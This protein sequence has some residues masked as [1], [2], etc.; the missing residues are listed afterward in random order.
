MKTVKILL[1][2]L[3]VCTMVLSVVSCGIFGGGTGN[4]GNEIT[5]N[6]GNE[7]SGSQGGGGDYVS[8]GTYGLKYQLNADGKSYTVTGM[9]EYANANN[10][11]I[12]EKYNG[13]P[14]TAIGEKAFFERSH[15]MS[16]DLP[17]TV[18]SIGK[19]AF[20]SCVRL[21]TME[22]PKSMTDGSVARGCSTLSSDDSCIG[23]DA[24]AG[25]E[26][27]VEVVNN[28]ELNIVAGSED[29][30]EVAL[31][32]IEVHDGESKITHVGD[33]RFY[34]FAGKNYL[35]SYYGD[36][37]N[38][39]LPES[40]NG[41]GYHINDYA[42]SGREQITKVV[43][44]DSVTG[45]GEH[46]FYFCE[47]LKSV[48]IGDGV[49]G[50][51]EETFA[52]CEKLESIVIGES[53]SSIGY[54][55]FTNCV[56][57]QS[58][59]ISNIAAWCNMDLHQPI[60]WNGGNLYLKDGEE[61]TL[62]TNLVIP[63]G[64][65]KIG[66]NAFHDCMSI[67]SVVIPDSVTSIGDRAFMSCYNIKSISF[68]EGVESIG[69]AA[70]Y[71]AAITELVIPDSVKSIADDAF[72]WCQSLESVSFGE[73]VESIGMQ[74]FYACEKLTSLVIP[75]SVTSIGDRAF[76]ECGGIKSIEIAGSVTSIGEGA[77]IGCQSLESVVIHDGVTSI[78]DDMFLGANDIKSIVIPA[79]VTYIGE[80]A[81][82]YSYDA[83]VYISDIAAWYNI[84]FVDGLSGNLYLKNGEESTL[85][86]HLVIPE[87]VTEIN[88]NAFGGFGSVDSVTIP[89][90]VTR[91]GEGGLPYATKI[92]I[93]DIAAWCNIDFANGL[94]G[95][96]YLK[97]GEESTLITNLVI[98]EG[99]TEIKNYAFQGCELQ[100]VVIPD[101]VTRIGN[102]AFSDCQNL[103]SI[104]IPDSVTSIG[105]LAFARCNGLTSVAIPDSVTV[106]DAQ[107]FWG[108]SKLASLT[109][110]K[111]LASIG[112][113][114][115]WGCDNLVSITVDT[116][117]TLYKSIDGNLYKVNDD[118]TTLTLIK[119]A[120]DKADTSFTTPLGVTAIASGAFNS[121]HK[122]ESVV[123][124]DSVTSISKEAFYF[125]QHL[126]SIVIGK[127]ATY[128][129]GA[130]VDGCTFLSS[131]TV[132][133]ANPAYKSI[134]GVLFKKNAD[135]TLTLILY[136]SELTDDLVTYTIPD[137]V[138]AIGDYAFLNS[139]WR[140]QHLII[141]DSVITIGTGAFSGCDNLE[142]VVIGDGVTA[143]GDEAFSGCYNL[144]SVVLGN[145]VTTIGESAFYA[146]QN[147]TSLVTGK[148]VTSIGR[149]AFGDCVGLTSVTLYGNGASI[150]ES[151]FAGCTALTTL[152]IG[153]GVTS[154]GR[155]AFA[156]CG[157]LTS[158]E[159]S[160]DLTSFA[161]AAFADCDSLTSVYISDIAAW[162]NIDF[163]STVFDGVKLYL[164][165]GEESTLITN[166]V[167]PDG[168]KLKEGTFSG[169][170][171]ITSVVISVG[172]IYEV[173]AT[174][175]NNCY[176]LTSIYYGGSQDEWKQNCMLPITNGTNA[177]VYY[178]SESKPVDDGD[179]WH[180][181]ANGN[182]AVWGN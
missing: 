33:Y 152:V 90:S 169:F 78:G 46:A 157:A 179:F 147:L 167:I 22:I 91:I 28:S 77:F 118:G 3:C 93:S 126:R 164:K 121:C 43:I 81:F 21:M 145:S 119:Y 1:A 57:L 76:A 171:S 70:F 20:D 55:A 79:S 73:G 84:D 134:D 127:G 95:N 6:A 133:D 178:Y 114:A 149:G 4:T 87:G 172:A 156:S 94:G 141:S 129:E 182:I 101:S 154:I 159:I 177:N 89:A 34:S 174:V 136:V 148:G 65:A 69:D 64:V 31:N 162:C 109:I 125:C 175:F 150:G 10:I 80:R 135:S 19:N 16:V 25:C 137:G 138:S 110:G 88:R 38:L 13:L 100:S 18:T 123:F 36:D 170:S 130:M 74:A 160:A 37:T 71:G 143:I 104:V 53:V 56:K 115:F 96:L 139:G 32:A 86:T 7:I 99:V 107:A 166:L 153:D 83:N 155:G 14:V 98:P 146:C 82:G 176:N 105:N 108:C 72:K 44:P 24:F 67:E 30:G 144:E 27:L 63:E 163:E 62:L 40:F 120:S 180:Y 11:I 39:V 29:Y 140:I 58:A 128:I 122:L 35:V 15:I 12:P 75:A 42:F 9:E 103:A 49:T 97:N 2:L 92:Y 116:A 181:D 23:E 165:N 102:A 47:N 8:S 113:N 54:G 131:I 158:V 52:F 51:G 17:D 41:E 50:I 117:N 26:N 124:S 68:G 61:S 161:S 59:Y 142:S 173:N 106:I 5:G 112:E 85:V 111:G 151:A 48:E 66:V 45:I 168:V 132:D 60:L